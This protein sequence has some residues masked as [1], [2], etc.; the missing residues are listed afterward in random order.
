LTTFTDDFARPDSSNLGPD[1][2]EVA[3][4]QVVG[5]TITAYVNG[6]LRV[7]VVDASVTTGT[8]VGLRGES[9]SAIRYD[10]FS[11]GDVSAGATLGTAGSTE[12]AQPLTGSKSATLGTATEADGAQALTG[13]KASTLGVASASEAAQQLTGAKAATLGTASSAETAQPLVGA[14]SATLGIASET[15]AGQALTGSKTH[16]LTPAGE[17]DTAL[18]LGTPVDLD[19]VDYDVGQPCTRE[20]TGQP[21]TT[22]EAGQ[23]W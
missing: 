22:W 13:S 16:T 14:K 4:L 20:A 10:N 6:T 11:A 12:T 8:S 23:P 18:S 5:S 3:K 21:Y 19:E 17:R 2:A 1:W 7:S 9:T 15:D